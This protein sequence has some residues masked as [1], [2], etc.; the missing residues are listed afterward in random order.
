MTIVALIPARA[1]SKRVP[2]K[3]MRELGQRPLIA[4]TIEAARAALLVNR[5]IVST[6][7]DDIAE[8]AT[9][10]GAE[11]HRRPAYTATDDAPIESALWS[12]HQVLDGA[13]DYMVTLQPTCP[14]RREGLIDDCV[15]LAIELDADSVWTAQ[16]EPK[17]WFWALDQDREWIDQMTWQ[18]LAPAQQ[19]HHVARRDLLYRHDGS[20]C[21]SAE[22][23]IRNKRDRTG[24]RGYPLLC[25]RTVDID[26]DADFRVASALLRP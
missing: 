16:A 4:W 7:A 8:A 14:V 17:C 5:V 20:V 2:G 19:R 12:V 25:E 3:N 9:L 18:R 15:K 13:Y 21:V 11:V 26:T 6:D 24:G 1:G 10:W 23:L 22:G